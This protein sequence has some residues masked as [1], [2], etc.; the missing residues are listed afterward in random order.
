[1]YVSYLLPVINYWF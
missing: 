1:M